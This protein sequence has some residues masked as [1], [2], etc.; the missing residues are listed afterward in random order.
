MRFKR[1]L[2]TLLRRLRS[3]FRRNAAE[4]ELDEE[5]RYHLERQIEQNI[6]RGVSPEGARY[7]AIRS[8]GNAASIKE[9]TRDL[10]RGPIE[11]LAQDLR[12]AFRMIRRAPGFTMLGVLTLA[13]G[14]GGATAMFSVVNGV[15]LRPLG[16]ENPDEIVAISAVMP[17]SP[18]APL[19]AY[20]FAQWKTQSRTL[21]DVAGVGFGNRLNLTGVGETEQL[22]S[23]RITANLFPILGVQP[24]RGRNFLAAEERQQ[25]GVQ[26]VILSDGLWTR[27]FGRD[28]NAVGAI[29]Q[30]N[31]ESYE[32]VGIMPPG[33]RFP[34]N[35]ELH[36]MILMP[37]QVDVWRPLV[38]S[39]QE[40][41]GYF[42]ASYAGIARLK[43][44]ATVSAAEAELNRI[45]KQFPN[46]LRNIPVEIRLNPLQTEMVG[47]VRQGLVVLMAAVCIVLAISCVNIINLLLAR[48]ANHRHEIAVRSALGA[49]R[50]Q[51]ARIPMAES[52][53]VAVFG[54]AGGAL[55][56][57]W[58]I[59]LVRAAA[60]FGLPR[61]DEIAIDVR[62]LLFAVSATVVSAALCGAVPA[63]RFSKADPGDALHEAG[64][65]AT[66]SR[67]AHRLR[68][69]LVSLESALCVI[70]T[71]AAGLLIHSFVRITGL[72]QGFRTE[73]AITA[74]IQ[75][76]GPRYAQPPARLN[77]FQEVVRGLE[78][79]P[80]TQAVGAV[81]TL[82]LT[83]Q[84]NIMA[85]TPQISVDLF[86]GGAQAEYRTA[87]S[88]YFAAMNIP[89]LRGRIFDD[90]ADPAK[91]AVIT[92]ETAKRL[93]PGQ[94]PL[95]KRFERRNRQDVFTIVGVVG[96]VRT[97]GPDREPPLMVYTPLVE[98]PL[99][100][101]T[102][103]IRTM[104]ISV[105]PTGRPTVGTPS[106]ILNGRS[107]G[108]PTPGEPAIRQV[109]ASIDKT[110][111]VSRIRKMDEI[112]S[113]AFATR[114]FQMLILACFAGVALLLAAIGVF[115][116]VSASVAQRQREIGIRLALGADKRNIASLV[117][118]EG[119]RPVV[120]GMAAGLIGAV[121]AA[122]TIQSLLF[123]VAPSDFAS[124]ALGLTVLLAAAAAACWIPMRA[125]TRVD[126][127]TTIRY[128]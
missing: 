25:G 69:G 32:V 54:A 99:P 42:S 9:A 73:N 90:R 114:R 51:L 14:I 7:A 81:S 4:Q 35:D 127:M 48:A 30:L 57:I 58:L 10:W 94:D 97:A 3:F 76:F 15:L 125:A 59:D 1:W 106:A 98:Q 28:P 60:P 21:E 41:Q 128:E 82:P 105:G 23:V 31:S 24:Q 12:H 120:L 119:L 96:N 107:A 26:P 56:A 38:F 92:E 100:S 17:S 115:G 124:Y 49:S 86:G 20:Y 113:N 27:R 110:I 122:Q 19:S 63:W 80:G 77:F 116:V 103:V 71:I 85:V 104:D 47:R 88:G 111:S 29:I 11:R 66:S 64:R 68:A 84:T 65:S 33:F 121:L 13:I 112:L 53:L 50:S 74:N 102:F 70:L 91:T 117:L 52:F 118:G 8:F 67:K 18:A 93:W 109:V 39:P 83:G 123:G 40:T 126:P 79:L 55:L 101:M 62:S 75:L 95:G 43:P 6:A 87:T 89:L 44:G 108:P 46:M 72:D 2:H 36:R 16:Y 45:L 5:L 78:A 34:K 61:V 22:S 37:T